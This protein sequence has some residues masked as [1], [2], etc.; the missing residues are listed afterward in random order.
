LQGVVVEDE[1]E[2][3]DDDVK[4]SRNFSSC[5][6]FFSSFDT[7]DTEC[8]WVDEDDDDE[9]E[10][11]E[12]RRFFPS[13]ILSASCEWRSEAGAV[14]GAVAVEEVEDISRRTAVRVSKVAL[15]RSTYLTCA[16]P[17]IPNAA[18]GMNTFTFAGGQSVN[19][20]LLLLLSLRHHTDIVVVARARR[21]RPQVNG[22]KN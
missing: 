10:D 18:S 11:R 7:P 16:R 8:S 19:L 13:A 22:R 2:D 3:E 4:R 5:R 9:N 1:D 15:T 6:I 21:W 12:K 14:A 17:K 20:M